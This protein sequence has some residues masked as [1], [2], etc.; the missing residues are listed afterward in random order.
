MKP[1]EKALKEV[2]KIE[3]GGDADG[4]FTNDPQDAGGETKWG[5]TKRLAR[6]CGWRQP[7]TALTKEFAIQVYEKVFWKDI[8]LD[9][10]AQHSE[11]VAMELFEASVNI[12][13]GLPQ[14]WLQYCLNGLN[15]EEKLYD[16]IKEDGQ[17]GPKTAQALASY[18][19]K[20]GVNAEKVLLRALNSYQ[21]QFYMEQSRRRKTDE[22]FV[23]GWFLQRVEIK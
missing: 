2:L 15:S 6:A 11:P 20:R 4:G 7:M 5:I 12:G 16:D 23:F 18:L 17:I 13:T 3:T 1:F 19:A 8:G 14:K 9:L 10:I 22:K 21:G